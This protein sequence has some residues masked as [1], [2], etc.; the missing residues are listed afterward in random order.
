ML[1]VFPVAYRID[2]DNYVDLKDKLIAKGLLDET[3]VI[4]KYSFLPVV[5]LR[6]AELNGIGLW[7]LQSK[8]KVYTINILITIGKGKRARYVGTCGF[9]LYDIEKDSYRLINTE[10]KALIFESLSR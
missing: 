7:Y 9:V 2:T 6:I 3:D 10:N 1:E 4:H 8:Y 5:G